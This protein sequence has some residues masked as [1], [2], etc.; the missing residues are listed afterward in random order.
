VKYSLVSQGWIDWTGGLGNNAIKDYEGLKVNT[1]LDPELLGP[2]PAEGTNPTRLEHRG[3]VAAGSVSTIECQVTCPGTL[4][5]LSATVAQGTGSVKVTATSNTCT[6][7]GS[8][9]V[10]TQTGP[11]NTRATAGV[12]GGGT[13]T[14]RVEITGP[15]TGAL[16]YCAEP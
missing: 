13:F 14:C 12:S 5:I 8:P 6:V 15:V 11:G 9:V 10:V 16:G 7:S 4:V 3:D 1:G 2:C